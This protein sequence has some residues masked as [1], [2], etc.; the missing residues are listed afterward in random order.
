MYMVIIL[1]LV[2]DF[3]Q[4]DHCSHTNERKHTTFF[5]IDKQPYPFGWGRRDWFEK[6][7]LVQSGIVDGYSSIILTVP[8]EEL[9]L[10]VV[11][12]TQ[13]G[14]TGDEGKT[15]LG[16]VLGTPAPVPARRGAPP[17]LPRATL[18]R[19]AGEYLWGA[20]RY[21]MHLT[22]DGSVLTLRWG[23]SPSAVTLTPIGEAEFFDRTS[24]SR[25]RFRD[26]GL[27]WVQ[28]GEETAANR[29]PS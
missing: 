28:N 24:F 26:N 19:W 2:K 15:L 3:F 1:R 12:N 11:M 13:S 29:V 25:I 20:P 22:S 5:D 18:D 7:V 9:H 17:V 8:A 23:D 21:P 10:V 4:H 14:F 6:N 16:I 27:V